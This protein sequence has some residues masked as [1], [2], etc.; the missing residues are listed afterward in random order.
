LLSSSAE[1]G[2]NVPSMMQSYD[3]YASQPTNDLPTL[4][5]IQ[6]QM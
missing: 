3:S 4:K 1:A 2:T 5:E 6:G